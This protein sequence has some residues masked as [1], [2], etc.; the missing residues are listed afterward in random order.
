[1]REKK[2]G[3]VNKQLM[4]IF[5][6]AVGVTLCMCLILGVVGAVAYNTLIYQGEAQKT[7]QGQADKDI[8]GNNKEESQEEHITNVL[9]K[10]MNKTVAILGT[11][12]YG[13]LT[14]TIMVAHFNN[15]TNEVKVI[16]VPRDTQVKWSEEQRDLLP[17]E[18]RWVTVSKLN[19]MTSWGGIENVRGL[20]IN[21]LER[22]LGIKIDN[23]IIISL[24]AFNDIVDAIGGV[25]VNVPQRMY[26]EEVCGGLKIDLQPGVQVLDGHGAEQFVRFRDYKNGD[27]GRIHA[28][29]QFAEAFMKKVVSPQIM[30]KLPA[31]ITTLFT[32]VKTDIKLTEVPEYYPYIETIKAS[33][34]AFY[35]IPG[36]DRRENGISYFF[37]DLEEADQMV[38]ELFFS[39]VN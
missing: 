13:K 4:K 24:A 22:I 16:S 19:E 10:R 28:Q 18:N 8:I 5:G 36:V 39:E 32:S 20:T 3:R 6:M 23:Y 33:Q 27:L 21:Q 31:I 35:R 34:V 9:D 14:D 38:K 7:E 1:M 26:K 37:V 11:D 12:F 15:Q 17:S 29:Q 30:T 25:E 2:N